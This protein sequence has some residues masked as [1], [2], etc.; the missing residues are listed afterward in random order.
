VTSL[1]LPPV[2][3]LFRALARTFVPEA[4]DLDERGW[5]EAEAIVER[6]LA[7]RPGSVR[8]QLVLLMRV[9]NL[10]PLFRYGRRFTSLD[11]ATRLRFLETMQDARWLLLRRGVWGVRTLAF[12]GYYERSEAARRIG[13]RADAAGWEKRRDVGPA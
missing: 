8:R 7:T 3:P 10:L 11:A 5:G 4:G 9:L 13:Y 6:F 1:V 12:M 2:R